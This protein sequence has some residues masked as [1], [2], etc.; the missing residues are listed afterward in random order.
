MRQLLP[1]LPNANKN[2]IKLLMACSRNISI[3]P[4][5]NAQFG[6]VAAQKEISAHLVKH[7]PQMILL[8]DQMPQS[9]T[10]SQLHSQNPHK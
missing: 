7:A 10:K 5:A 9:L 6:T 3:F 8:N 1:F 2:H 4:S